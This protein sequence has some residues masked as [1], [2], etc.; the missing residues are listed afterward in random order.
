M[1]KRTPGMYAYYKNEI[2]KALKEDYQERVGYLMSDMPYEILVALRDEQILP[3]KEES[4]DSSR[5]RTIE[6][7]ETWTITYKRRSRT[8][9]GD[10]QMT[11]ISFPTLFSNGTELDTQFYS[12]NS[13][14]V[15]EEGDRMYLSPD[16]LRILAR[17]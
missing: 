1:T 6:V 17:N 8:R 14:Q 9:V 15:E 12:S 10:F 11:E 4:V 7:E 5:N 13:L 16:D 2:V 3:Q